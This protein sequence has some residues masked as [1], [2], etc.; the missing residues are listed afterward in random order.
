[1]SPVFTGWRFNLKYLNF[2]GEKEKT[3]TVQLRKSRLSYPVSIPLRN[4]PR[5][6][7][8][9]PAHASIYTNFMNNKRKIPSLNIYYPSFLRATLLLAFPSYLAF[10]FP[11]PAPST[12]F[13]LFLFPFSSFSL[14]TFF[15]FILWF[16]SRPDKASNFPILVVAESKKKS[17]K[18]FFFFFFT[19][20]FRIIDSKF[21]RTLWKSFCI[22]SREAQIVSPFGIRRLC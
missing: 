14:T 17:M 21:E 22:Q 2:Q 18:G 12:L 1:M 13:F 20:R 16:R 11:P 3:N 10:H 6:F 15:F 19:P 7:K 5:G 8:T 9:F 4:F